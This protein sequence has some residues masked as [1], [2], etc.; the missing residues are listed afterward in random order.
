MRS[1]SEEAGGSVHTCVQ[2]KPFDVRMLT[3]RSIPQDW[4]IG[5]RSAQLRIGGC[6][7]SAALCGDPKEIE[8]VHAPRLLSSRAGIRHGISGVPILV[9]KPHV[10]HVGA[11][12]ENSLMDSRQSGLSSNAQRVCGCQRTFVNNPMG[13]QAWVLVWMDTL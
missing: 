10:R 7:S 8:P 6:F 1:Y 13:P 3:R 5:E 9:N 2:L 4:G 12:L 11:P